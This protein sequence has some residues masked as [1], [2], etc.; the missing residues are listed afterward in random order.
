MGIKFACFHS[1]GTRPVAKDFLNKL[2]RL[3]EIYFEHSL[4]KRGGIP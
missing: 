4:S 2:Q 1:T 3:G